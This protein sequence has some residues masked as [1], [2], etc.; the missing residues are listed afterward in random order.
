MKQTIEHNY[1]EGYVYINSDTS[2]IYGRTDPQNRK[3]R[4]SYKNEKL[5]TGF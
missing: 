2:L 5:L 1:F 4:W 3:F